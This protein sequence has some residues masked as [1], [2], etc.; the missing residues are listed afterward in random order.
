[1]A[2]KINKKYCGCPVT[3]ECK[4]KY[5]ITMY[6]FCGGE[7][8]DSELTVCDITDTIE[9]AR[10]I[11][12]KLAKDTKERQD[13]FNQECQ[14]EAENEEEEDEEPLQKFNIYDHKDYIVVTTQTYNICRDYVSDYGDR[15]VIEI[16]TVKSKNV[17]NK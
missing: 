5:V 3:E 12:R 11:A 7:P 6:S 4:C 14:D 1:M 17:H 13:K 15:Y 16:H 9:T 8:D 2:K 10:N